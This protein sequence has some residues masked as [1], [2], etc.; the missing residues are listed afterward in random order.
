MTIIIINKRM[1]LK[2]AT[3]YFYHFIKNRNLLG[4][5]NMR[6]ENISKGNWHFKDL[7]NETG[8]ARQ[9]F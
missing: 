6:S 1:C 3:S 4:I 5:T 8:F 7:E 2:S 9:L